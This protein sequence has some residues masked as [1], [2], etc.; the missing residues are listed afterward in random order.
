MKKKIFL[1]VSMMM[2]LALA[3]VAFAYNQSAT[4][5]TAKMDCCKSKDSCPMKNM[6]ADSKSESCCDDAN[7]C[8]KSGDSCPMKTGEAA[9]ASHQM[10]DMNHEAAAGEHKTCDCSCCAKGE[11]AAV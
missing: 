1:A 6:S 9:K 5:N 7:C 4:N 10:N 11:N 2:V 3:A 8:C